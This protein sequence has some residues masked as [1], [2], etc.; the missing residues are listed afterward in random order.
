MI[1]E[2]ILVVEDDASILTG[3]ADLLEAEGYGISTARDGEEA[4][5]QNDRKKHALITLDVMIH[6]RRG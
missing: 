1:K 3:L 4:L 6:K 2:D 5:R